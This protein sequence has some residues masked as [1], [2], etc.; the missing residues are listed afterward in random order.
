M[1]QQ[2]LD[3]Q[4]REERII[5]LEEELKHKIAEVSRSLASKEEEVMS[6]K[7]RFKDEKNALETTNKRASN[8]IED[9]KAKIDGA[10]S[11]FRSY[12]V[13]IENSP[14]NVLRNELATKQIEIVELESKVSKAL[15]DRDEY[16]T[17]Y[18]QIKKDMIDLKRQIDREKEATLTKQAEELDMIKR[19]MRTQAAQEKEARELGT[20]K[21][22]LAGL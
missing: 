6:I 7:K 16:K 2:G 20:L 11:K 19:Q 3:L 15:G 21:T 5:Q 12:K 10:E 9:L 1:R 4:R 13:E 22:Q 14:L 8:Q 17:K 18:D